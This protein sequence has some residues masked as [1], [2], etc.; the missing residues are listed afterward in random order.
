MMIGIAAV[1]QGN[2]GTAFRHREQ[3]LWVLALGAAAGAEWLWARRRRIEPG[4]SPAA[5]SRR[6]DEA[7]V[8]DAVDPSLASTA[9]D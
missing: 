4:G 6:M 7:P 3:V 8:V 2:L 9:R 1:T 5:V